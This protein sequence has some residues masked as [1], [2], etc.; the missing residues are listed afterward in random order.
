MKKIFSLSVLLCLLGGCSKPTVDN[1]V[2]NNFN[3]GFI[4]PSPEIR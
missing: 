2:V 3:R 4:M 1:S